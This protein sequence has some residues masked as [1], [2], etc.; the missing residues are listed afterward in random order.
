MNLIFTICSNNYLAQAKTLGDSLLEHNPTYRFIIGL[1]DEINNEIDYSF[2]AAYTIVPVKYIGITQFDDLWKKYDIVEFNT[3]VKAS[4]FKFLF[5]TYPDANNI[6]YLDPDIKVYHKLDILE[7]AFSNYDILLTPHILTPLEID[8]KHPGENTFLNFGL[9][10]LGFIGVHRNCTQPSCFLDWWENRT[11]TLGYNNPCAGLYVDQL[12]INLV[13]IFFEKVKIIMQ[14]GL[15]VAPWNLHERKIIHTVNEEFKIDDESALYFFH[16]SSYRFN[17][18]DTMSKYYN[19]YNFETH[20][21]LKKLYNDYNN[22]LVRNKIAD[23]E[24]IECI[25]LIYQKKYLR[26]KNNLASKLNHSIFHTKKYF[27]KNIPPK[28]LRAIKIFSTKIIDK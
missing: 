26:K 8:D 13:P 17:K 15:N 7:A 20:S 11:L 27:K 22:D 6:C 19:R 2:L 9:Y 12:W 25:Y 23:F 5:L 1:T 21:E 18:K 28:L 10:N 16:F 4:Y 14:K 24:K 3:C